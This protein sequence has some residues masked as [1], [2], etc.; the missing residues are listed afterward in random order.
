MK[1][2]VLY[3]GFYKGT[4]A[5]CCAFESMSGL[6]EHHPADL[7]DVATYELKSPK[8]KPKRSR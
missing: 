3:I 1:P 2:R 5:R 4:N 8:R 7:Y 6:R